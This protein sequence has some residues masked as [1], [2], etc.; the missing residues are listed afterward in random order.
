MAFQ[1]NIDALPEYFNGTSRS[2]YFDLIKTY[3]THYVM[4]GDLGGRLMSVTATKLCE[5]A[6]KELTVGEVFHCLTNEIRKRIGD[7]NIMPADRC[8]EIQQTTHVGRLCRAFS[9]GGSLFGTLCPE[10]KAIKEYKQW[11]GSLSAYPGLIRCKLRPISNL[12]NVQN[13]R[14]QSLEQAIKAY[15]NER[16][17]TITCAANACP[18]SRI[19][20][21]TVQAAHDCACR[22]RTEGHITNRDCCAKQVG[23]GYLKVWVDHASGL[24]SDWF[25]KAD[26][27]VDVEFAG[28]KK[29]TGFWWNTNDPVF[30][31]SFEFGIMQLMENVKL[32]ITVKEWNAIPWGVVTIGECETNLGAGPV[33]HKICPLKR[34]Y[35]IYRYQA[36]CGPHLTGHNCKDYAFQTPRYSSVLGDW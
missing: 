17:L 36:V 30:D 27:A 12:V 21:F 23:L 1:A 28:I 13:A 3:G 26:A 2:Q 14:R 4:E 32:R 6:L 29:E 8:R 24:H 34:G 25:S 22:C 5:I 20:S 10:Q 15:V 33:Q 7:P 19:P 18:S 31:K 11:L 35:L 16:T 9:Q